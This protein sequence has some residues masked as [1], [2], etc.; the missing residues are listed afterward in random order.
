[1]NP[2]SAPL[3]SRF[4]RVGPALE[5]CAV[6]AAAVLLATCVDRWVLRV[7]ATTAAL[8]M[9]LV[10]LGAAARWGLA[11]SIFTSVAGVLNFNYFFLPPVGTFTIS[12][13]ENWVA[14]IAFLATAITASTLSA[15]GRRRAEEALAGRNQIARLYELSRA[16]LMDEGQDAVRHSV[17]QAAQILQMGEIAFFDAAANRV[18][19]AVQE[20]IV[21]SADLE[22]VA[23]TG[24]AIM[25]HPAAVIPVRLGTHIIGSLAT[26]SGLIT[27]ELRDSVANLL[28][29][30][31]E[32]AHALNRA[33]AAEVAKR[34]E[35]FKSS[36]LDGLAH[37]L[38]TPLTA[39]RTCVTHMIASPPR[40][41]ELRQELLS[42][43]DQESERLQGTITEAVELARIESRELHL[44]KESTRLSPLIENLLGEIRDENRERYSFEGP[45]DLE[46]SADADLLRRAL[47]QV[48]ENARKYG[49]PREPI[50]IQF[51]RDGNT[52][53]I[54][55]IDSGPGFN[56]DE[57]D[58]VFE[59]FYRGRRGRD[60]VEG[61]GMGLAIARGIIEA[62]GGKIRAQ[63]RTGGGAMVSMTL[64]LN[65]GGE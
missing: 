39:I 16:L 2:G 4:G 53:V 34:N 61:T 49:S 7:N 59:K 60:K 48:L 17:M 58:R 57:L 18:Y 28:A 36:L 13:P 62:H 26:V 23:K 22:E 42:I 15:N 40:T 29:I 20:S 35:E 64:P 51:R 9:L 43:I 3:R 21:T 38:K 65:T 11:E 5:H 14:L 27:P 44:E 50:Q 24:E 54:D 8:Y 25:R 55:V 30:N 31:Y 46:V 63:N 6:C 41:E 10:V 52:A 12:D 45:A 37:D 47:Q 32:R 33:A 56:P 19:G 1:M